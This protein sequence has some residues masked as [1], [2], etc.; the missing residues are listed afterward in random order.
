MQ[1]WIPEWVM[2]FW[3]GTIVEVTAMIVIEIG[4]RRK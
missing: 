2:F 1:E 4:Y 3:T